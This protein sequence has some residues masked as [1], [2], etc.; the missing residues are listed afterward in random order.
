MD[1]IK[2]NYNWFN[3]NRDAVINGHHGQL[4][5]ITDKHVIEYFNSDK[6]AI[7]YAK[8]KNITYGTF[9]IQPCVS[10]EEETVNIY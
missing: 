2:E 9:I 6:D 7:D 3:D 5:F 10:L 4:A 8:K 1:L